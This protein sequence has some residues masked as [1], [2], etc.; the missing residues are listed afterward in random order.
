MNFVQFPSEMVL[1]WS[2]KVRWKSFFFSGLW[3]IPLW[4]AVS[5]KGID[6]EKRNWSPLKKHSNPFGNTRVCSS[7]KRGCYSE[8]SK[9]SENDIFRCL[10]HSTLKAH[11][12]NTVGRKYFWPVSFKGAWKM[13]SEAPEF[14]PVPS[15]MVLRWSHK[16]QSIRFFQV[17]DQF[18]FDKLLH[19]WKRIQ[20]PECMSLTGCPIY[21]VKYKKE[22]PKTIPRWLF[23]LKKWSNIKVGC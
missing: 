12:F 17:F 15:E 4:Q 10:I 22:H 11:I 8:I 3:P 21:M 7:F 20:K 9:Y 13:L 2:H 23:P 18:H 19:I 5:F 14:C 6:I 16:V 1:Q